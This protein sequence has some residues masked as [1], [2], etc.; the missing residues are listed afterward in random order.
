MYVLFLPLFFNI[1]CLPNRIPFFVNKSFFLIFCIRLHIFV[2]Y[3]QL[4]H[5]N[6][7][8]CFPKR[9]ILQFFILLFFFCITLLGFGSISIMCSLYSGTMNKCFAYVETKNHLGNKVIFWCSG[10]RDRTYDQSLNRRPLYRWATT[11][12]CICGSRAEP[13]VTSIFLLKN[14]STPTRHLRALRL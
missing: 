1:I 4:E 10:G 7:Y 8:F 13:L 14:L 12:C 2:K 3:C 11:E 6:V 5:I 9:R